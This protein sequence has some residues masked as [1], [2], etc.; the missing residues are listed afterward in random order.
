MFFHAKNIKK[1]SQKVKND[2]IYKYNNMM[3]KTYN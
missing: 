3:L 2:I 1:T